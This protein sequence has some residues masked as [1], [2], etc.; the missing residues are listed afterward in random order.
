MLIN[1]LSK[2]L[3]E[4]RSPTDPTLDCLSTLL[5][6]FQGL[7]GSSCWWQCTLVTVPVCLSLHVRAMESLWVES[8][9]WYCCYSV[10]DGLHNGKTKSKHMS[11]SLA[12][13]FKKKHYT[14]RFFFWGGFFPQL[15][16]S[17]CMWQGADLHTQQ[18]LYMVTRT[19]QEK[20]IKT[21]P[22]QLTL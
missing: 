16:M 5:Y 1:I 4:N 19:H 13:S 11:F 12:L 3:Y 8:I 14:T 9:S 20:A 6:L 15:A 21:T 7:M 10:I 17:W 18:Q 22:C 2:P